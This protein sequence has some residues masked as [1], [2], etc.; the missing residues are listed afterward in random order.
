[1]TTEASPDLQATL[2]SLEA[3]SLMRLQLASVFAVGNEFPAFRPAEVPRGI[4][5]FSIALRLDPRSAGATFVSD[6]FAGQ[7]IRTMAESVSAGRAGWPLQVR[8]ALERG[9][10][11]RLWVNA[12][13][14]D[15]DRLPE[16]TWRSLEIETDARLSRRG[17]VAQLREAWL[18]AAGHCLA[19]VMSA[20]TLNEIDQFPSGL[21]EGAPFQSSVTRHERS[22]VN[23]LRC[24]QFYGYSCWVCDLNFAERYGTLGGE[25]IE[26]HHLFPV[27]QLPEGYV[28]N[29]I[30]E[31][32]P[33][34]S[35]CHSMAHRQNPPVHPASLRALLNLEPRDSVLARRL[36]VA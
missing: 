9:V 14:V 3:A 19:L 15:I 34:C 1:M 24:V 27:A 23:R 30:T 28:V 22:P 26:V 5:M 35:N 29:P 25:F 10:E 17:G 11:T 12:R 13:P 18:L 36:G 21:P 32:V 4:P 20:L 16:Q 7:V 8:Q 6:P 33:L 31:M 2:L